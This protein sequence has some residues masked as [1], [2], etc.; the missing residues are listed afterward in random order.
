MDIMD[1]L[2][3]GVNVNLLVELDMQSMIYL[4]VALILALVISNTINNVVN[5][6]FK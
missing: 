6:F 4:A 3:N 1:F 5:G 2:K